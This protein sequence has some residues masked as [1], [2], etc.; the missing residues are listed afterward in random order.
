VPHDILVTTAGK[1]N[2]PMHVEEHELVER[3]AY[4]NIAQNH[5]FTL[6][7]ILLLL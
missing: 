2:T 6:L 5:S 3:K 4:L 1:G 7:L